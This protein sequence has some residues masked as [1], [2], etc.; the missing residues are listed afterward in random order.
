MRRRAVLAVAVALAGVV[1]VVA[2]SVRGGGGGEA[3]QV[4]SDCGLRD[5]GP[6]ARD[7]YERALFEIVSDADRLGH[8]LRA[9]RRE[10]QAERGY[11]AA[12]CHVLMH[13]VGR[14]YAEEHKVR[15]QSLMAYLPT[16][17]DPGCSAGF[18]HGVITR[19]APEIAE[20]DPAAVRR[21]C[22]QPKTRFLRYSCV[23]GL[24]HAYMRLYGELLPYALKGC[25]ALGANAAPDCA[26]GAYHDYWF[27]VVGKDDLDPLERG[28]RTPARLCARQP[29][30]FVI[31][32]WYRGFI[33]TRPS[34]YQTKS[35]DDLLAICA[36]EA[37]LQRRGCITAASVI[38]SANPL[39][40]IRVCAALSADDDVTACIHG[41]K[42]Q[43]ISAEVDMVRLIRRCSWF[44][45]SV[46]RD[47]FEWFGK[48]L[49]V[50]TDGRFKRVG[51]P[52]AGGR[53]AR[54]ACERGSDRSGEALVT[55]S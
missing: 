36:D 31:P 29:R 12:N 43:N 13:A 32:C 17:N 10:A 27:A 5:R 3:R 38:G 30:E 41:V 11:V 7:C 51:C 20:E 54:R 34:G 21:V 49:A 28:P 25:S 53:Q 16:D 55:F 9:A 47:C 46:A 48:T 22:D 50:V 8:G 2:L 6:A 44:T 1:A 52:R 26:Q 14:R 37:G 18:A 42:S 15:L 35:A 24:G 39:K 40:Q 19:I 33:D 23:H 4:V 45:G